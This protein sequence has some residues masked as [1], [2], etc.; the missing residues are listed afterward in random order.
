MFLSRQGGLRRHERCRDF[1]APRSCHAAI[2]PITMGSMSSA[3]ITVAR[4]SNLHNLVMPCA[5]D[6]SRDTRQTSVPGSSLPVSHGTVDERQGGS[7]RVIL[8]T[9]TANI[10]PLGSRLAQW[11][12]MCYHRFSFLIAF[13]L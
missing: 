4:R 2:S 9:V 6:A 3:L 5:V 8:P 12:W 13:W 7:Q 1:P 10:R 11:T